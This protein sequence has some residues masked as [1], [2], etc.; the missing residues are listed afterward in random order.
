MNS[1]INISKVQVVKVSDEKK[2]TI[3]QEIKT[4]FNNLERDLDKGFIAELSHPTRGASFCKAI[5]N[6]YKL[7]D[8]SQRI[9]DKTFKA[10]PVESYAFYPS[11]YNP[12]RIGS[13]AIYGTNSTRY[14]QHLEKRR[15]LF[16][17]RIANV[18]VELGRRPFVDVKFAV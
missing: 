18:S 16:G 11:T 7:G 2:H 6:I 13:V 10:V 5:I 12:E 4:V 17:R 3:E 15:I 1:N 9:R 8:H 14:C